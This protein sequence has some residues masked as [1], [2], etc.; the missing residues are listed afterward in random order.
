M[1]SIYRDVVAIINLLWVQVVKSVEGAQDCGNLAESSGDVKGLV[2]C[3]TGK[4]EGGGRL[5]MYAELR[6][7]GS[8]HVGAA[9]VVGENKVTAGSKQ[10]RGGVGHDANR[11]QTDKQDHGLRHPLEPS[12]RFEYVL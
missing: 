9:A 12:I 4:G 10:A 8:Q 1:T 7:A 2:P 5:L 6:I 11:C 3:G